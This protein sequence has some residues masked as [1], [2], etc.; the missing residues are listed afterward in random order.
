MAKE[1]KIWEASD[2][3]YHKTREAASHHE[4]QAR[5]SEYLDKNRDRLEEV[6]YATVKRFIMDELGEMYNVYLTSPPE[7]GP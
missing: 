3:T 1:V 4:G 6:D 2:G 7:V 5:L